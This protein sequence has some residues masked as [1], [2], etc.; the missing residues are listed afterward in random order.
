M[1][2]FR[3][4]S[5]PA[6]VA[7]CRQLE[8]GDDTNQH[9]SS[10]P[11]ELDA[12]APAGSRQAPRAGGGRE[13]AGERRP[14][15]RTGAR[16]L[17]AAPSVI[18]KRLNR[19]ARRHTLPGL[20]LPR[21]WQPIPPSGTDACCFFPKAFGS[22]HSTAP[23]E[24]RGAERVRRGKVGAQVDKRALCDSGPQLTSF[25]EILCLRTFCLTSQA[26]QPPSAKS[27]KIPLF[28]VSIAWVDLMALFGAERI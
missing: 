9:A 1:D 8:R 22:S 16:L 14:S 11:P 4:V 20:A 25:C 24:D 7:T 19:S 12:G 13:L 21:A 27:R 28:S 26:N 6:E 23:S 3:R 5:P 18:W 17:R 2:G 10:F 15:C